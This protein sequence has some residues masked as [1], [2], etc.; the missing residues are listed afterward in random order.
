MRSAAVLQESINQEFVN[1]KVKISQCYIHLMINDE[2][3]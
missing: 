1:M 3:H 2:G